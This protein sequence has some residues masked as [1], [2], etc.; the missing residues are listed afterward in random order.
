MIRLATVIDTF[1][2][3]FLAHYQSRL[4]PEHYQALGAMKRCRTS[5]S[6]MLKLQCSACAQ[7]TLVPHSWAIAKERPPLLCPCCGAPMSILKTQIRSWLTTP[8]TVATPA[9]IP[10][11]AI[12]SEAH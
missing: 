10:I 11:T 6:P 1:A 8:S 12:T 3:D 4:R 5:A 9:P 2:A 7:Q